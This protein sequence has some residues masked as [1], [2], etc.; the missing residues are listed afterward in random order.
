M[1]KAL[2]EKIH[3]TA[4]KAV[5]VIAGGGSEAIGELLRHGNGSN[6]LLDA[7]VPYSQ[8]AF[9]QFIG[10]KPDKFVSEDAACSLAMSALLRARKLYTPSQEDKENPWFGLVGLGA[11]ASLAK[12]NER[13]GRQ[14]KLFVATQTNFVTKC[15]EYT[16]PDGLSREVE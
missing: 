7:Q 8:T 9:E 6:T 3:K 10:G 15:T 4:T 5:I 2:C 13:A 14:H 11:T 12:E 16:L 1:K